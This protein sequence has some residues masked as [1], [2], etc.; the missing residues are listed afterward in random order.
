MLFAVQGFLYVERKLERPNS[1]FRFLHLFH[2]R[3]RKVT[4]KER[5]LWMVDWEPITSGGNDETRTF[6]RHRDSRLF[7]H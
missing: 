6:D 4:E 3:G 1:G 2:K 7:Q 5:W